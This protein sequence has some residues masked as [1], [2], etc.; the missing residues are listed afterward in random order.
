MRESTSL[1]H[2]DSVVKC[3]RAPDHELEPCIEVQEVARKPVARVALAYPSDQLV[4]LGLAA[5]RVAPELAQAV[6]HR[7]AVV[8]RDA[9]LSANELGQRAGSGGDHGHA[10]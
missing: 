2:Y 8:A 7:G 10:R 6:G 9:A 4:S 3:A 5:R 1:Q